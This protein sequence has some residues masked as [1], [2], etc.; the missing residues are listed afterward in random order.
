MTGMDQQ[1]G[2]V[3]EVAGVAVLDL[4]WD[5]IDSTFKDIGRASG[6]WL[7]GHE[8]WESWGRSEF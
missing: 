5:L 6:E 8:Y 2:I 7:I 1:L 3:E 4:Y